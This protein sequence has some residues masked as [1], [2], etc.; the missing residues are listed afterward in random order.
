MKK[1]AYVLCSVVQ[2]ILIF[3]AGILVYLSDKKMGVMRSLTYR[4]LVWNRGN[5]DRY[6]LIFLITLTILCAV[7]YLFTKK[8]SLFILIIFDILAIN[9]TIFFNTTIIFS[10]FVIIIALCPILGLE[11]LKS[12]KKKKK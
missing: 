4:N 1:I 6:I 3:T 11:L 5:L 10:Y 2:L 7:C 8:F 12:F 9:F